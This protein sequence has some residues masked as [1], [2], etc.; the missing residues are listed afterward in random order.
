[1][2]GNG[3]HVCLVMGHMCRIQDY[4]VG[5]YVVRVN[6]VWVYVVWRN[7]GVSTLPVLLM[8]HSEVR[9]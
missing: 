3:P 7:V 2:L 9:H 4:V 8:T 1:M 5:D 6:V